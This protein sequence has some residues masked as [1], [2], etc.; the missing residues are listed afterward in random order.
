MKARLV[1]F[2][3]IKMAFMASTLIASGSFIAA[4]FTKGKGLERK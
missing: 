4:L 2:D 3:G 1:Y